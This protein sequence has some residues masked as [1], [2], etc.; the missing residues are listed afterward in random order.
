MSDGPFER[1]AALPEQL[2]RPLLA[3][4]LADPAAGPRLE[5]SYAARRTWFLQQLTPTSPSLNLTEAYR[6]QGP[7]AL[8]ALDAAV[9]EISMRH[10]PLRTR[11]L[12][13][14]GRPV[15]LI[16][17]VPIRLSVER[18][19][20]ADVADGEAHVRA[21][22]EAEA[23]RPFD[24]QAGPLLRAR[25]VELAPEDH[26]L[27]VNMHHIVS[28]GWSL[29]VF[30]T[31]LAQAY[32]GLAAG[33]SS[34]LAPLPHGYAD[35]V[36]SQREL[37][38]GAALERELDWWRGALAGA[39]DVLDLPTDRPRPPR[40]RMGA[41]VESA[42]IPAELYAA[43]RSLAA[44][45]TAT[46]FMVLLAAYA[47]L[48]HRFADQADLL[49]GT[50][51]TGRRER[52]NPLIGLFT[53]TIVVRSTISDEP[54]FAALV[55]RIRGFL[56]AARDHENLPHDLLVGRLNPARD[57]SRNPLF[58]AFFSLEDNPATLTALGPATAT[59]LEIDERI[60]ARFDVSLSVV[61]ETGGALRAKLGFD[62]DLFDPATV[63]QLVR[64]YLRLL[65]EV[66]VAPGTPGTKVDLVGDQPA[67]IAVAP[68]V[69]AV[70][71]LDGCPTLHSGIAAQ[72]ART[73]HRLALAGHTDRLTYA[74]LDAGA[75]SLAARLRECGVRA[76][77][78][79][80]ICP[81]RD[82][83]MVRAMLAV[84]KCGA[85]YLPLDPA[86]PAERL[87]FMLADTAAA[88]VLVDGRYRDKVRGYGGPTIDLDE[89]GG[90]PFE[91][92]G[93]AG[94]DL[95]YV[96][97]TSGSTGWPKAVAV[98][99]RAVLNLIRGSAQLFGRTHTHLAS[100]SICFDSSISEIFQPLATGGC[101]VIVEHLLD[102]AQAPAEPPVTIVETVPSLL[103]ELLR[104]LPLPSSVTTV[105]L[106][107]E[108][109]TADLVAQIFA[110]GSVRE[111]F[112][113]YGP[114]EATVSATW[115]RVV[116]GCA[117]PTI[118]GPLPGVR[119]YVLDRHGRAVPVGFRGEL[120]LGGI[121]IA[122]GYL[123]RAGLTAHRFVV[124]PYAGQPGARMYATGDLVRQRAD[125]ELVWL[126]RTD[127]QVKVRG[128]R[129]E[130]GEVEHA[131]L[132]LEGVQAA[133]VCAVPDGDDQ[134][135]C[136]YVSPPTAADLVAL[137]AAL[138]ERLPAYLVPTLAVGLPALPLNSS[139]KV[140]LAAL[141]MPQRAQRAQSRA[142][143][144]PTERAIAEIWSQV[145]GIADVGAHDDFFALGGHSLLAI[146]VL[147]HIEQR[148]GAH[149]D[150]PTMFEAPTVAGLAD[151]ADTLVWLH[152]GPATPAA[153]ET[154]GVL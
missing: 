142:P 7:L 90:R 91:P 89:S 88:A 54:S 72:A 4:L 100:S 141:P 130:L 105:S 48:L 70:D 14:G 35:Y 37:T 8:D 34:G 1:F 36:A 108:P 29:G 97:Y 6:V 104:R 128:Q 52:D 26:L 146:Q 107:G 109:L 154:V 32:R 118:G 67:S 15:Q 94:S 147:Y 96:L 28:D 115:T 21:V 75:N 19:D 123:N 53:N 86:H 85:A 119:T 84:L 133:V 40:Q 117:N 126:G 111:L 114:T 77:D 127:R 18:L 95:A 62:P 24:L 76:G 33:G 139:G 46:P 113:M 122:R 145:L 151:L 137:R 38:T 13:A 124:D 79:V 73:P 149:L 61:R 64:C 80:A 153:D 98:E 49:I 134:A 152:E 60:A 150:I 42:L 57:A 87:A 93:G 17:A 71:P 44:T 144:T 135:L 121:G 11:F 120:H 63:A 106:G 81:H 110:G 59:R 136:A 102:L 10:E 51:V 43:V 27:L 2:R 47:L 92:V 82:P 129:V 125:G 16:S 25:V 30:C 65:G 66:T 22:V 12:D 132:A 3:R 31:E 41:A 83:R 39:P 69:A 45:L 78:I 143:G 50:A 55:H 56:L 148:L 68:P 74:E 101:A 23:D 9:A 58:Q 140:D 116:E 131:L 138:R 5:P 112:N 20:L 99:H 103:R